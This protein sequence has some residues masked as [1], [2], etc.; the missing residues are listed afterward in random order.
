MWSGV[1]QVIIWLPLGLAGD[2]GGA[3]SVGEHN[4][5]TT[6]TQTTK[7]WSWTGRI[8]WR[9]L[10]E[11]DQLVGGDL[12]VARRFSSSSSSSMV[13]SNT[14]II[15]IFTWSYG[16]RYLATLLLG[17]WRTHSAA[18]NIVLVFDIYC[19]SGEYTYIGGNALNWRNVWNTT[20]MQIKQYLNNIWILNE[21]CYKLYITPILELSR[22]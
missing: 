22:Q 8:H 16:E 15:W 5:V 14:R 7:L 10:N 2:G 6:T 21:T 12:W 20:N 13:F 18:G 4:V 17:R 9:I 1:V 3:R 19:Y 11:S